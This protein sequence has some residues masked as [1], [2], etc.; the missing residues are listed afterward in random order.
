[1]EISNFNQLTYGKKHD[2]LDENPIASWNLQ[3]I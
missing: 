1:M 2:K 3:D